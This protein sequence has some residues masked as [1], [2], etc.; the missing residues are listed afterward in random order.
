M[1]VGMLVFGLTAVNQP[2]SKAADSEK[3]DADNLSCSKQAR[4]VQKITDKQKKRDFIAKCQAEREA[5]ENAEME[6][7]R[8]EKSAKKA[9]SEVETKAILDKKP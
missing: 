3:A 1:C 4:R 6:A 5:R 8:R 2:F 7:K 9:K